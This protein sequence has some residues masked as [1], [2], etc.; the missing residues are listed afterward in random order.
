MN[1]IAL[2][3]EKCNPPQGNMQCCSTC[4]NC[5][6]AAPYLDEFQQKTTNVVLA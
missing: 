3:R 2:S 1:V 4:L 6:Q 5:R